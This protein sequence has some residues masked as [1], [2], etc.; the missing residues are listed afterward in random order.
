MDY[1]RAKR[2]LD[3]LP[4]WEVGRAAVG[5]LAHYLPRMRALLARLGDPQRCQ[6]RGVGVGEGEVDGL[7]ARAPQREAQEVA[8]RVRVLG[9]E[10]RPHAHPRRDGRAR[11]FGGAGGGAGH[12]RALARWICLRRAE[13]GDLRGASAIRASWCVGSSRTASWTTRAS[14]TSWTSPSRA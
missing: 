14:G 5:P 12:R 6:P 10:Q 8:L 3:A 11:A 2:Y 13:R 1:F 7:R 4:D 9:G